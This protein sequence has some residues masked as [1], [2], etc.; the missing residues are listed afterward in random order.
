MHNY[1]KTLSLVLALVFL[2]S[3]SYLK[4][5][6][7][8]ISGKLKREN[9]VEGIP[10]EY[11]KGLVVVKAQINSDTTLREFIFDTGAFNSKIENEL[12]QSLGL[13]TITTKTNAD[14]NG[15]ERT[16]EVTRIDSIKFG[17]TSFY[18]IG[19]GKVVYDDNSA[20]KCIASGGII[21][22]NLIKLANW[23]IDYDNKMLYFSDEPFEL[24]ES[25]R[26]YELKFDRPLLSAT[27]MIEIGINEK[28]AS[29]I[30]FDV[31]YNGSL[32]VPSAIHENFESAETEV[33][34]DQ[35]I[36]GIYGSA[37]DTLISKKLN[38]N[39]GGA[40]I[41][42][43]V[44]FSARGKGLLG[45]EILEHFVVAINNDDDIITLQQQSNV[46]TA[47]SNAFVP[48]I[49]NDSLWV[50]DR[51][52]I[53]SPLQLGDTLKLV[54]GKIPGQLF[55]DHCDYIMNIGSF[56]KSEETLS[57]KK[58]DDTTQKVF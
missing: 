26:T 9:F 36:R 56:L 24:P 49:L 21:G 4:N 22:A 44:D 40:N 6:N 3:C 7:L 47:Q 11:R 38:L 37:I 30:M 17:K 28:T 27:P 19:A 2:S 35:S 45:N 54:N 41:E 29:S 5:V 18:K 39:I 42:A 51:V 46:E 58:M 34:L 57:V 32:Y 13:K 12:A 16:I 55:N 31:G 50:V 25:E 20:S 23:K 8:L 43:V 10:F 15:N 33:F 14:T 52:N 1:I 53:K 48:G